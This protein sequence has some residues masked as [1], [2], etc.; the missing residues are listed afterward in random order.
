M[1]EPSYVQG[2]ITA[3]GIEKAEF[4]IKVRGYDREEVD[5]F[6]SLVASEVR[7]LLDKLENIDE[8]KPFESLGAEAG[9]LLQL[10]EDAAK[11]TKAAAE[12]ELAQ[13]RQAFEAE[14]SRIEQELSLRRTEIEDEGLA[15]IKRA[16]EDAAGTREKADG[17]AAQIEDQMA[18]LKERITEEA[19][20]LRSDARAE[21]TVLLR[22]AKR[23]AAGI[24]KEA[25]LR[26]D[27]MLAATEQQASERLRQA[28]EQLRKLR[29]AEVSL[30]NR[31]QVLEEQRMEAERLRGEPALP[32]DEV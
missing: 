17:Y 25:K 18:T 12:T 30:R 24:E 8:E 11:A 31:I 4:S 7:H 22:E 27:K 23:N 19:K 3:E 2:N 16:E 14:K 26:A 21:Y 9:R 15:I 1:T 10:A 20:K 6:L 29:D 13:E 32:L 5:G 28:K